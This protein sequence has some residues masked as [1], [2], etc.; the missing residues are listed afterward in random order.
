[1]DP[2]LTWFF[3][4]VITLCLGCAI[5][6]ALRM[7]APRWSRA[8]RK[9]GWDYFRPGHT[10]NVRPND[11]SPTALHAAAKLAIADYAETL[12]AA[13]AKV[14]PSVVRNKQGTLQVV[15]NEYVSYTVRET[16]PGAFAYQISRAVSVRGNLESLSGLGHSTDTESGPTLG[17]SLI[18]LNLHRIA[19]PTGFA[20]CLA[21][22]LEVTS[23]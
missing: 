23:P 10:A 13:L 6:L 7:E 22:S 9:F 11:L 21:R 14:N 19:D 12:P 17:L 3:G 8:L 5:W 2:Q 20:F 15:L 4:L 16:H 1:M 18:A